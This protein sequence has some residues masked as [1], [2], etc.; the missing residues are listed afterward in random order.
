MYENPD[1][2]SSS[3]V[4]EIILI[5]VLKEL[6]I[7]SITFLDELAFKSSTNLVYV[8]YKYNIEGSIPPQLSQCK[9]DSSMIN[10]E[11]QSIA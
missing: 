3:T 8:P 2:L 5:I 7:L 6:D 11:L 1:Q 10:I 4:R 9:I